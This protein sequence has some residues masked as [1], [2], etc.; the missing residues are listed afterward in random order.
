M[1]VQGVSLL[2]KSPIEPVREITWPE[3]CHRCCQQGSNTVLT[4]TYHSQ[5]GH[6]TTLPPSIGNLISSE[7]KHRNDQK[8]LSVLDQGLNIT[9]AL[10]H[11][12]YW[13]QVQ[14]KGDYAEEVFMFLKMFM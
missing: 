14:I 5:G 6:L 10:V 8:P 7:I 13:T 4:S 11:R 9:K 1:C 2:M 12:I 3:T